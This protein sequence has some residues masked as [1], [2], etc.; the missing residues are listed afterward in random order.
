MGNQKEKAM[1]GINDIMNHP[2]VATVMI[3]I[4]GM[5][6]RFGKL[7]AILSNSGGWD[8]V[9]VS[10]ETR[11]PTWEEMC[12]IKDICFHEHEV[13]MQLHPAKADHINVHPFVLHMWRPQ[14]AAIPLPPKGMV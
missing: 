5:A 4:D 8:H 14:G 11:C 3:G 2:G 13:A 6:F 9:S 1:K 10:L 7:R 12:V